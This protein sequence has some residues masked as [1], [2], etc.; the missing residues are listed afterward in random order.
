MI[1]FQPSDEDLAVVDTVRAFVKRELMPY[2]PLLLARGVA[3]QDAHLTQQERR[4]LR[5][6]AKGS[7][8]WGIDTPEE[9]G[10]V[11]L[12][13]VTQALIYMELNR[14]FVDFTFG[15]SA[16]EVLYLTNEGQAERYLLPTIAGDRIF[17]FALSEP[18]G[19]SD[20]RGIKTNAVR[21][22]DSWIINGEKMWTTFGNEADYALVFCR[23]PAAG[24]DAIT[25]FLVDRDMGWKS[26]PIRLM[27]SKDPAMLSFVDVRVPDSNRLGEIGEGMS[28]AMKFIHRNRGVF[29]PARQIGGCQ[30]L[31]EMGLEWAQQ[32]VTMGKPLIERENIRFA[33]AESDIELKAMKL[34]TLHAAWLGD[35]HKDVRQA[36]N[37]IKYFGANAAN[38]IVDRIVQIHGGMG[39]AKELPVERYYRD[40]RV[41]RIYEGSD[42]MQLQAIVRNLVRGHNAVAEVW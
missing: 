8:L 1:D 7:G 28:L 37:Q 10:G 16:P 40:F 39:Y 17:C 11:D 30:R 3:G 25:A 34:M 42:E 14:T 12:S 35:M 36:C 26:S 4:D 19:G 29:L 15:G 5:L 38:R 9:Y 24:D 2:E 23:T 13:W 21:D 6:K 32:R 18:G 31:I 27:G 41:E 33:L 20:A 22:G